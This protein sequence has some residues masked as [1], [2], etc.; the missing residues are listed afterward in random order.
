MTVFCN[1]STAATHELG[2]YSRH[3]TKLFLDKFGPSYADTEEIRNSWRKTAPYSVDAE[4]FLILQTRTYIRMLDPQDSNSR[5]LSYLKLLTKMMADYLTAYTHRN[6]AIANRNMARKRIEAALYDDFA[7]IKY[8]SAKQAAARALRQ[9][10]AEK[11][12][13]KR[14]MRQ[15][16]IKHFKR[17]K[18][19]PGWV[20]SSTLFNQR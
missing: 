18:S 12:K 10:R 3:I 7:Y 6:P 11:H 16:A 14:R 17:M 2:V 9:Q 20:A 19:V 5:N 1:A 4:D 15:D 8:L 13:E